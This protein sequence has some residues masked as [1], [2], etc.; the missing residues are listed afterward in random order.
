MTFGNKPYVC[1][2]AQMSS[3]RALAFASL[4]TSAALATPSGLN[5]I[6]T[7][8][9]APQRTLVLQAFSTV[10]G[11]ADGDFNVGF[12]TGLD[13]DFVKFEIGADSR[14]YSV[15][16]GGPVTAQAK[17]AVPLGKN[18]P[19]L[20]VGVANI[21]FSHDYRDRAGD[22][23]FY[24]VATQAFG[25]I[26]I[27]GGCAMQDN[28]ALPFAGVDYTFRRTEQVPAASEGKAV[29]DG[30]AGKAVA[31]D[32]KVTDLFTLRGDV[33]EQRDASWLYSAGV[34]VPVCKF[35]VL[36][37]WANFPDNGD[38]ASWTIKGNFVIN[39]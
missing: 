11:L 30:K 24:A 38:S 14:V 13:F 22:E 21:T 3:L 4:L 31:M 10:G 8:D 20:A 15:N 32:T 27:H 28:E 25:P 1:I 35:F 12:K 7:A 17:M 36:E 23:F 2:Y 29:A 18:L 16:N 37:T 34:L 19:T 26:R 5:S 39:F 33:I 6:P 9:T